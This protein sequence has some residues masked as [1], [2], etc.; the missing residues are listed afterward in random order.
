[1]LLA[2]A[3]AAL[4]AGGV[5]VR[6][7]VGGE[8]GRQLAALGALAL[9][10]VALWMITPGSAPGFPGQP[11]VLI[12]VRWLGP[13]VLLGF[14]VL[15]GIGGRL[16]R[17]ALAVD[18]LL[19]AAIVHGL[20]QV[21]FTRTAGQLAEAAAIVMIAVGIA[22]AAWLV[23]PRLRALSAAGRRGVAIG[24]A[25]L[26]VLAAAG[27]ARLEQDAYADRDYS[28]H[29]PAFA[30]ISEHA[31]SGTRIGIVGGSSLDGVSPILPAF[32]PRLGNDVTYVGPFVDDLLLDYQR[33]EEFVSALRREG[34]ELLIVGR[35]LVPKAEVRQERWA[36]SAGFRLVT[37]SDRLALYAAP[38]SGF[39]AFTGAPG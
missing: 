19:V 12:T 11:Q 16:G 2:G 14:M 21:Y 10:A 15:G 33:R 38:G 35:G 7:G 27:F 25:A 4:G 37:G 23:L 5:A 1:L 22:A 6:R 36:R 34:D 31:P 30:W 9:L 39:A 3:I 29:D 32:G 8:R 26:A 28:I 20:D 17:A 13:A 18:A 24:A